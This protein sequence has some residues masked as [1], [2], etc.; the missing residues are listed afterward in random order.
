MGDFENAE[1]GNLAADERRST[2]IRQNCLLCFQSAFIGVDRRPFCLVTFFIT[3][4]VSHADSALKV[5]R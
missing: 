2:P 3:L 5:F 1:K 4:L